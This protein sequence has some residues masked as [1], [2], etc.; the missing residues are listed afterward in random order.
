MGRRLIGGGACLFNVNLT[1]PA[2]G[3]LV[4]APG[5]Q[6]APMTAGTEKDTFEIAAAGATIVFSRDDTDR[7]VERVLYQAGNE[8]RATR[9]E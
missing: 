2:D 8:T 7:V 1:M 3:L 6:P 4:Q 9:V 5:Q